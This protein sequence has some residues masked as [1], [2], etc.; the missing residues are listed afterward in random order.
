[1]TLRIGVPREIK[2]GENRV[3]VTPDGAAALAG[4]G[5]R[6]VVQAGAGAGSGFEDGEYAA[7]GAI[8]ADSAPAAWDADLVVKVKEPLPGE[9]SFLSE[10]TALF[11]YLH[12]AAYPSLTNELL[13]KRVTAV[14]YE[15][16]TVEG[17]LPL[18]RPMSEVAG[19][20]AVQAGAR[21]LEKA[22]GGRGVLLPGVSGVPPAA[23]TVLGA[24]SAGRS[25]ARAAAGFGADVTVLDILPAKLDRVR[26]DIPFP[27]RTVLSSGSSIASALAASDLVISTVLRV[28]G[29]APV[30]VT[31]DHLKSM[32][33]GAVLVD[34][35]IDQ[36]GSAESSRPTTHD[37][38]YYLEE[39]IVH[40]CV[41][42]MPA[43][44]PRTSTGAL[45]RATLPYVL[46]FARLGVEGAL[47]A[48]GALRAGLNTRDG[49]V[50]CEGVAK[51]LGLPYVPPEKLL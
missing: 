33:R 15:T 43:A 8:L 21:G 36:G 16:V 38:P 46:S 20:V 34:L 23:V 28:G 1:M 18:L 17:D 4:A 27:V 39:G 25:A 29:R 24:G 22:C 32:R 11:T 45:C 44:V 50:A 48:D 37:A 5:A 7:A 6:V 31:R 10:K 41:T 40:Y 42:N 13:A 19:I 14:A 26:R 47:R 9:Y 3:A 35:A 49:K 51:A 2:A 12:L 30:L